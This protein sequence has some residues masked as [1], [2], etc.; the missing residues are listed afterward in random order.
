[1]QDV[2]GAVYVSLH[3]RVTNRAAKHLYTQSL[4]YRCARRPACASFMVP[5]LAG[6]R[7]RQSPPGNILHAVEFDSAVDQ[8]CIVQIGVIL[9]PKSKEMGRT[10]MQRG[11]AFRSNAAQ[12]LGMTIDQCWPLPDYVTSIYLYGLKRLLVCSSNSSAESH[13]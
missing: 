8:G 12:L 9:G 10:M 11:K 5:R 7:R 4:G 6:A 3:V 1:M 2:F 13:V